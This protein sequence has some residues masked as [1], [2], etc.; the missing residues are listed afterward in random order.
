MVIANRLMKHSGNS[1]ELQAALARLEAKEK[2]LN[3]PP[4]KVARTPYFC[5]G[6]PHNTSTK[7][8][9]GSRAMAGIGC[10]GMA[11]LDARPPH[12][13]DHP[14]GRRGR[15]LDRPGAVHR[16]QAHL[17][18]SRR[19]HL[20]PLRPAGDPRGRRRRRQHHLQD[21]LQRRGRDDRRPA[22][23]RPAHRAGDHAPGRRRGRQEGRR[24]HRRARQ[25]P[26]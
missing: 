12:L 5:S 21:P 9:E 20:L 24:R 3:A 2:L 10:H 23:R 6:C 25:I 13:A 26:A 18:E 16:R 14:H 19:R 4:S 8:P 1:P 17:P 11:M 7:V 15:G 22:A